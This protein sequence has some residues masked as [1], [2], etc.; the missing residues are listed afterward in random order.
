V[1]PQHRLPP[2]WDEHLPN[3][4]KD[5]RFL[6]S[7]PRK[8]QLPINGAVAGI[9]I[10][11]KPTNQNNFG[12]NKADFDRLLELLRDGPFTA[13]FVVLA[14]VGNTYVAHREAEE[15]AEMLKTVQFRNGPYGEYWLLREDFSPFDAAPDIA[16]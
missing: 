8:Y 3:I 7:S 16:F 11:V 12:L 14:S 10:A 2:N 9:A 1:G 5:T 13:A 4:F 15:L 6:R